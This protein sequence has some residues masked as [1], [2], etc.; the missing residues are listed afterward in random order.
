MCRSSSTTHYI[1]HASFWHARAGAL[2]AK[3]GH[4]NGHIKQSYNIQQLR[5]RITSVQYPLL[6]L[7]FILTRHTY[8]DLHQHSNLFTHTCLIQTSWL[9]ISYNIIYSS[10]D[11][12]SLKQ[13]LTRQ[14][15]YP[16]RTYTHQYSITHAV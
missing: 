2:F 1:S 14:L 5:I 4:F 7:I 16:Q 15:A 3:H 12:Y 13:G 6:G 9:H 8:Q 11:S 10:S